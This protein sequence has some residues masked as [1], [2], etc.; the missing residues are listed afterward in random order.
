M[1]RTAE[2]TPGFQVRPVA[3]HSAASHLSCTP[4]DSDAI[5][6]INQQF[7]SPVVVH[8]PVV[9]HISPGERGVSSGP[10]CADRFLESRPRWL[11]PNAIE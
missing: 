4:V 5:V 8:S 1:G 7:L 2:K 9:W 11:L 10:A 3:E 6:V